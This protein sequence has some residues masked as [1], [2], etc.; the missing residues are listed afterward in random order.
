MGFQ[1][2]I[3][4]A[5]VRFTSNQAMS[6]L[7][8]LES[9]TGSLRRENERLKTQKLKLEVQNKKDS[10]EYKKLTQRI[11]QNTATIK[12]NG[13]RMATLRKH[14]GVTAMSMK[15]LRKEAR[16]LQGQLDS[17]SKAANPKEYARLDKELGQVKKR[18]GEL[19]GN[20]GRTNGMLKS[21]KAILPALGVAAVA[22]G[23]KKMAGQ[24]I[25][26]RSEFEKYEAVLSNT[27]GS[28]EAAR[29]E[30][31]MLKELASE[32]PFALQGLTGAYVK[33]VNQGFKPT[34]EEM[35]KMGD[36]AASTG[37]D[38]DMLAEAVIDAMVGENERLKE[39]GIRGEKHGDMI[40][41]TFKGIKTEVDFT[42]EAI[43]GY[44]LSLGEIE[45]VTGSMAKISA[46]MGGRISNLGDAWDNLL[47]KWGAKTSGVI[48]G[49]IDGII[50][51]TN[52]LA[53]NRGELEK[54]REAVN[55]RMRELTDANTTQERS[56]ELLDQLKG[57]NPKIVEGIDAQKIEY[58]KLQASLEAYNKEMG[59]RIY[60]ESLTKDQT[61][62]LIKKTRIEK[63]YADAQIQMSN[64][65]LKYDKKLAL[66]SAMTWEE[67]RGVLGMELQGQLDL[68]ESY[69]ESSETYVTRTGH[70]I[71]AQNQETQQLLSFVE[72]NKKL[73]IEEEKLKNIQ[74]DYDAIENEKE[75]LMSIL[76]FKKEQQKED[77][78]NTKKT[79][80]QLLDELELQ[81]EQSIL[82]IKQQYADEL[83]AKQEFD[84]QMLIQEMAYLHAKAE[85]L[86]EDP[87]KQAKVY[88]EIADLKI[89]INEDT[90]DAI[91]EME[92]DTDKYVEEEYKKEIKRD[93]ASY[94]AHVKTIQAKFNQEQKLR[95]ENDKNAEKAHQKE[96]DRMME[97]VDRYNGYA[98]EIGQ[99]LGQAVADGEMSMEEFGRQL[100]STGL[101]ILRKQMHL[102]IA[103][104]TAESLASTESI[105]TWGI[106][107][108]AKAAV[109]TLAVET[110]YGA[111]KAAVTSKGK[112]YYSGGYTPNGLWSQ[113][114]GVVHSDEF[115]ANRYS[116]RN[117]EIRQFLDVFDL[118]QRSGQVNNLNTE[119]ILRAVEIK[120]GGFA[121]GG[122]SSPGELPGIIPSSDP[123]LKAI[124]A[125]VA[126]A[127]STLNSQ[128]A[129]GIK[130]WMSYQEFEDARTEI[131]SIKS[132]V[133][134]G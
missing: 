10:A 120:R 98:M 122:Y 93:Q 79:D 109:L 28:Q 111:A 80:D 128:L 54:E 85:L 1:K 84:A 13:S 87:E 45:G 9:Q 24:M 110:A 29:A 33:L 108:A 14:V 37:K 130:A 26:V 90:I 19:K 21:F 8:K 119:A 81:N 125:A 5:E 78:D 121:A 59:N 70:I 60:L 64:L 114:Q 67:K 95:E 20:T 16:V 123:E 63:R 115:I 69:K 65:M 22:A 40:T 55:L 102:L 134:I 117:P 75:I 57:I 25:A 83:I 106:A 100:I 43:Q 17:T 35:R 7:K 133:N 56:I 4:E 53:E 39:F 124:N 94:D 89:Q 132:K 103:K 62:I 44:I 49:V 131:D 41:Y 99:V 126:L 23:L 34:K 74:S 82:L 3:I 58:S 113:P 96:L 18:M 118:A 12:Q 42:S 68:A 51:I 32:T 6:E 50:K 46:T 129:K 47:N 27:L 77:L 116:V 15:D 104:I 48:I 101:D 107:G 2:D 38:M 97:K 11:K 76:G 52:A 127:I 73:Q 88:Q 105:A 91:K 72:A 61:K 86:G 66:N 36:L 30:M 92:V 112:D 31:K 71:S